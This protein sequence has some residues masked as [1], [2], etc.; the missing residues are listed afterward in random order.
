MKPTDKHKK[1]AEFFNALAHPRRQMNL[2][3]LEQVKPEGIP[4]YR[5]Q[6]RTGLSPTTLS[7]HLSK[8]NA[9]GILRR[10]VKGP[11]TWLS[12]NHAAFSRFSAP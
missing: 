5:P 11:E 2:H 7:F 8:M 9:G 4:F 10:K 12:L 6:R 1:A 3:V